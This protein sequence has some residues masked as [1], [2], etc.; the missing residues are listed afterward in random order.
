MTDLPWNSSLQAGAV[1]VI[2]KTSCC[3]RNSAPGHVER[4]IEKR[5]EKPSDLPSRVLMVGGISQQARL[6]RVGVRRHGWLVL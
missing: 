6:A 3:T 1:C 4:S 2:T 5:K